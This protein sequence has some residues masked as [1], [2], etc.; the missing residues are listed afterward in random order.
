MGFFLDE[1]RFYNFIVWL[2]SVLLSCTASGIILYIE[3]SYPTVILLVQ[4][5]EVFILAKVFI[6][7]KKINHALRLKPIKPLRLYDVEAREKA[8]A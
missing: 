4:I 2:L 8:R 6:Y 5:I 1:D 7:V 3:P